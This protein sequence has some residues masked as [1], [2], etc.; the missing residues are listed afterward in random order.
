ML[1]GYRRYV[2]ISLSLLIACGFYAIIKRGAVHF[3]PA[4][5]AETPKPRVLIL[6]AGHGGADGGAVSVSGRKESELN[7]DI[8]QRTECLAAFFG[9]SAVMTRESEEL[10]Y[11]AE[12]DTIAKMKR[13]DTRERV[14]RINS[15]PGAVL[16]S[17][18]QNWYPAAQP[19]GPQ[20]FYGRIGGSRAFAE[21]IQ[22]LLSD[23]L[24]P[25]NRRLAV[26]CSDEVYI[27]N[28]ADCPAVLVEC[29][30]L[31]SVR[32]AALLELESYRLQIAM[33]LTD[34][35]LLYEGEQYEAQN[36]VFLH[37]VRQ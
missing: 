26:P 31:S 24:C 32:E 30:F 35:F 9:V 37:G 29:G 8:A 33:I 2:T 6:D 17:I 7:L 20:V 10:P 23:N 12:A 34:S 4:A 25:D 16:L 28:K 3:I 21:R 13:W 18:H 11:P 1:S 19:H 5:V 14:A 36:E 27:M 15:T 22:T